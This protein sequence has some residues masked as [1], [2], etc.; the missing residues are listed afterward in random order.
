MRDTALIPA[1]R[2]EFCAKVDVIV[3]RDAPL[4]AKAAWDKVENKLGAPFDGASGAAL[5]C[6]VF[7]TR[8]IC[9]ECK[10]VS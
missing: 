2:T 7:G 4:H 3:S 6:V 10:D 5:S 9:W 8:D 1:G